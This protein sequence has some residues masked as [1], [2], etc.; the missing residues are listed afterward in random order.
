MT[1]IV[2]PY[3]PSIEFVKSHFFPL[4]GQS[5]ITSHETQVFELSLSYV[6]A[7]I[8]KLHNSLKINHPPKTFEMFHLIFSYEPLLYQLLTFTRPFSIW[9]MEKWR[10]RLSMKIGKKVYFQESSSLLAESVEV[11]V[12]VLFVIYLSMTSNGVFWEV[13]GEIVFL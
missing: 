7:F 11:V 2:L 3:N 5:P 6:T 10:P 12:F 9:L 4:Q 13:H 8:L 1:V